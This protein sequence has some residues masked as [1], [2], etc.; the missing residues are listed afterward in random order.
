M[1][2]C[3]RPGPRPGLRRGLA[4]VS[5]AA[6]LVT[7]PGCAGRATPETGRAGSSAA[8]QA[9][10][11]ASAAPPAMLR[12][13]KH[14]PSQAECR[15]RL[16]FPCYPA[17]SVRR[18]Y[19]VDTLNS[20]GITGKGR[21]VVVYEEV[22]PNTLKQDLATFSRAMKLPLPELT[23]DRYAPIGHIAPFDPKNK[24][25]VGPAMEATLDTQIVHMLAPD[26]KIVVTQIGLPERAFTSPSPT[27]DASRAL[28][29][30]ESP[31]EA[32]QSAKVGAALML[33]GIAQSL[34][35]HRPD[36]ISI[37]FGIEEYAAAGNSHA[38]A[39]DLA[40]FSSAL[41]QV[42]AGGTTLTASTGDLGAAPPIGPGGRRVRSV[43]WPAADPSVLAVGGSRLHLDDEGRRTSPDTV[44]NDRSGATGGG[45]SQTFARP[46][47]QAPVAHVV[48][49]RR[50]VPDIS[51]DGSSTG[52]TLVY[53]GFL[54]TG[55]GWLPVGGTSEAAP[56][57]GALVALAN[58]KAGHRLG[59]VHEALY[60]LARDPHGGIVDITEG[61][62]GPDG[63]A[64]TRGYDL[65]SGLGTVDASVFVPRL[66]GTG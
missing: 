53:E 50:G 35:R 9:A 23:V 26:A 10:T 54:P 24:Q 38:P 57:F 30:A 47:Y 56:M 48:G 59:D 49:E 61:N 27:S 11:S 64:A 20:A 18:A 33:D 12:P 63:F 66:A 16:G 39:R 41:A 13:F 45:L 17:D 44:W 51:M 2:H 52:G 14:L 19:G 29:D 8:A 28:P 32:R 34:L 7:V 55:P 37:S 1:R 6:L 25:M 60:G 62:N 65:A 15:R 46:A 36:V 42:V 43:P 4:T 22:V 21:T 5:A 3:P 31:Q 58:Q 40:G